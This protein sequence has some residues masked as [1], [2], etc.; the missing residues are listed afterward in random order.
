MFWLLFSLQYCLRRTR[1]IPHIGKPLSEVPPGDVIVE[2]T[3]EDDDTP[4]NRIRVEPKRWRL[5]SSNEQNAYRRKRDYQR[6]SHIALEDA[7]KKQRSYSKLADISLENAYKKQRSYSKL[8]DISL[9]NAYRRKRDYQRLSHIALEN[10][11]DE[12]DQVKKQKE[13]TQ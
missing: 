3:I 12:D 6:L 2:S 5:L 10:Y 8:T 11:V 1:Y 13:K 7:Y 4:L 9:E